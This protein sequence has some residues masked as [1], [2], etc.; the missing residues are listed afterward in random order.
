MNELRLLVF[1][2]A[3]VSG[4]VKTRLMPE[5]SGDEAAEIHEALA[6]ETLDECIRLKERFTVT[7]ELWCS[8]NVNHEFFQN[9][10]QKGITLFEQSGP[11][12]GIK[13]HRG[14]AESDMKTILIGTDCPPID[15]DYLLKAAEQLESY[16]VLLGPAED[17]GY[18]LIGLHESNQDLFEGIAW[19]TDQ[20]LRQTLK[21]CEV[22]NLQVGLLPTIW[23]VDY[24]EDVQR[25][26][27]TQAPRQ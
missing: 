14:F 20:V 13:M 25:W 17:G 2:K 15:C 3:P 24:P 7:I 27:A 16:D 12:L 5:F 11:D 10:E 21:K 8:P 22:Q 6:A 19:S 23:D 4:Q 18:G 9:Y 26:R 1:C